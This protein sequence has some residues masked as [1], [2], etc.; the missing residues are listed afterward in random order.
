MKTTA[1][2]H[3]PATLSSQAGVMLL[4]ALVA[5]LLFSMGVIA[6]IGLQSASIASVSQNKFRTDASYLANQII[7]RMWTDTAANIPS[8]ATTGGNAARTAWDAQVAATLP[9][10]TGTITTANCPNVAV[11]PAPNGC[12]VSVTINWRHPDDPLPHSYL[13]VATIN[14]S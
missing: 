12:Q 1:R 4:E 3:R 8:Y 11:P 7:A 14:N 2:A 9:S 5:I 6:L 13:A 10:G